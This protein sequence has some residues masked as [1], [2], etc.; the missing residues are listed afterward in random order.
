MVNWNDDNIQLEI[1]KLRKAVNKV[2]SSSVKIETEDPKYPFYFPYEKAWKGQNESIEKIFNCVVSGKRYVCLTATTGAGKTAVFLTAAWMLKRE[3]ELNVLVIEPR[4]D[5]QIQVSEIYKDNDIIKLKYLFERTKHCMFGDK[6]PCRLRYKIN[7][8]GDEEYF[9]YLGF[10]IKY[11]CNFECSGSYIG[12]D[13]IYKYIKYKKCPYD[14]CKEEIKRCI[15]DKDFIPIL[16]P[17]NFWFLRKLNDLVVIIDECDLFFEIVKQELKVKISEIEKYINVSNNVSVIELLDAVKD[18]CIEEERRIKRLLGAYR[19]ITELEELNKMLVNIRNTY[20]K[21]KNFINIYE[22]Y[23]ENYDGDPEKYFIYYKEKGFLHIEPILPNAM[24]LESLF[25]HAKSFILVSATF[26]YYDRRNTVEVYYDMKF[27]SKILY[28]PVANMS[29]KHIFYGKR[30]NILK[31]VIKNL[32]IPLCDEVYSIV[33]MQNLRKMRKF[34]L[35]CGSINKHVYTVKDILIDE[36]KKVL[37]QDESIPLFKVIEKFKID[38]DTEYICLGHGSEYGIDFNYSPFMVILK[39]P[40]PASDEQDTR[41]RQMMKKMGKEKFYEWYYWEAIKKLIQASGRVVRRPDDP[42]VTVIIDTWFEYLFYK[43]YDKIPSW[44]KNRLVM[45]N[46]I[47]NSDAVCNYI[48]E[49]GTSKILN[50]IYNDK[51]VYTNI[52][53]VSVEFFNDSKNKNE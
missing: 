21:C 43:F 15:Y 24:L 42:S 22:Y 51:D 8:K 30:V 29:V 19:T 40:F 3:A 20:I 7:E 48:D 28:F 41:M 13:N 9:D 53:K 10:K 45:I 31:N 17:G 25:P 16:N 39:V 27:A 35:Y 46:S 4:N 34:V 11:P 5:L 47:L 23:Q 6:A 1:S 37:W 18:Y 2:L 14:I 44:F 52:E 50:V 49:K 33:E 36:G 26:D 38:K 32:I 12:D